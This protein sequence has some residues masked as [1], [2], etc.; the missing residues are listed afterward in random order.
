MDRE[1]RLPP[2]MP[3]IKEIEVVD[4]TEIKEDED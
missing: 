4:P 1:D 2:G 3:D